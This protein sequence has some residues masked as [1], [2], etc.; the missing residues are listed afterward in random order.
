[1]KAT[2]PKR[3]PSSSGS[4]S[5]G[6]H[7]PGFAALH[8]LAP[9]SRAPGLVPATAYQ[10]RRTPVQIARPSVQPA[11]GSSGVSWGWQALGFSPVQFRRTDARGRGLSR[12]PGP[13]PRACIA[14]GLRVTHLREQLGVRK[15]RRVVSAAE[16]YAA[17]DSALASCI[18]HLTSHAL[19]AQTGTG[20]RL[21][22]GRWSARS[23]GS[24]EAHTASHP[25][26]WW[27]H[28][29][30]RRTLRSWVTPSLSQ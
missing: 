19:K 21:N 26:I 7:R 3:R 22:S 20:Q 6:A 30:R 17:A 23:T 14:V 18:G 4:G 8:G 2:A 9:G 12:G 25:G 24:I 27:R 10:P 16:R 1:V 29:A 28:A 13:P 11:S 15:G 5:T